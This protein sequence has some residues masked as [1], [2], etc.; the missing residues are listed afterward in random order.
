MLRP[1]LLAALSVLAAAALPASAQYIDTEAEYAVIMDYETGDI[2]FS[3]RGSEAMIP[4]SMTK[5]MTAHVVYDA[6]ERGEISL[7]DE[8]VV[9]E[10][11]WREGG[12][13]TGGSTMGLK[14][15]ETPTVEQ[16]LRGVIVLSGNDACIVLAEGLAGSEEAFADRMTDLAHELGLASANFENASGLP[17]EGHVIS[18]ADL[19]KLAALEIRKYPQ[20]YKYYS[21]LEMS[22]NGI[23]QGNR[24]PLLY[25]MDGAD[26]LK[27]GHLEVS[28]YGLTAS[29]ERDGQRMIMVLNGL[30]SSQARAEES[31][32]LMRLAFTAFDTRTVEPSE[33]A[34]AELPVW[35]GEA[36]TVGV[37]Y[38]VKPMAAPLL[39]IVG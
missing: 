18:A 34:F 14:I 26:G 20:Y 31:E 32:R 17:A 2:L 38:Y 3:K 27:T 22:W 12:W 37:T 39:T 1:N 5:I 24:N 11:A 16:L 4:A 25:S 19:A 28:G 15:G 30:P 13:A 9:S 33:E 6:I 10:R 8:L 23:T 36:S 29:A 35:N 7:D 21:E